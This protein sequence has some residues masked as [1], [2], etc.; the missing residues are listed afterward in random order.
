MD[1]QILDHAENCDAG[2]D[3]SDGNIDFFRLHRSSFSAQ[4]AQKK[5]GRYGPRSNFVPTG[6]AADS[7]QESAL[8]KREIGLMCDLDLILDSWW[9]FSD[10]L[11][12]DPSS[13]HKN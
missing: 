11:K 1:I 3:F 12:H 4:P 10:V 6:C 8:W 9:E 2:G 7:N 5:F 13:L